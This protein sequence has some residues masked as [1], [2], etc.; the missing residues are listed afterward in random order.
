MIAYSEPLCLC[1]VCSFPAFSLKGG[2][3]VH[4]ADPWLAAL[5]RLLKLH[6]SAAACVKHKKGFHCKEAHDY[7][8]RKK[9]KVLLGFIV[10]S[11][12]I[13]SHLKAIQAPLTE[14]SLSTQFPAQCAAVHAVGGKRE[15]S[16]KTPAVALQRM[17]SIFYFNLMFLI[18]VMSCYRD[19][20]LNEL[21]YIKLLLNSQTF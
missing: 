4:C 11:W 18:W 9:R 21:Y 17:A 6:T 8:E 3:Y 12:N 5:I 14:L 1:Q 7:I 2:G 20:Q 16:I 19:V 10:L 15:F 13:C